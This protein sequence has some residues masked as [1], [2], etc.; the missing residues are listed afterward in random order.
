MPVKIR[1][2]IL[3]MSEFLAP[4]FPFQKKTSIPTVPGKLIG[5]K[6]P[7]H[8]WDF[9]PMMGSQIWLEIG[10]KKNF[11]H[12]ILGPFVYVDAWVFSQDHT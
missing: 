9:C 12:M 7:E 4:S 10:E 8:L 11:P 1:L 6:F 3:L 2:L 5:N